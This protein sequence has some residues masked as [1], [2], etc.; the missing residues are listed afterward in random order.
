MVIL[1][2]FSCR[3]RASRKQHDGD[4]ASGTSD[5]AMPPSTPPPSTPPPSTPP[6]SYSSFKFDSPV[7]NNQSTTSVKNSTDVSEDEGSFT[8]ASTKSP[9]THLRNENEN[10]SFHSGTTPEKSI[11]FNR[12]HGDEALQRNDGEGIT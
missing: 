4:V 12:H 10:R 3:T 7:E 5:S 8:I 1:K 2:N 6:P 11:Q 9:P